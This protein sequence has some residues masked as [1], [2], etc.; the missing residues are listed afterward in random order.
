M[1][2]GVIRRSE[3]RTEGS[4]SLHTPCEARTFTGSSAREGQPVVREKLTR[5]GSSQTPKPESRTDWNRLDRMTD[6]E[7][8]RA[9][10]ADPDAQPLSEDQLARAFRPG[11]LRSLR[12]R[13]GLSQ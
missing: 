1:A 13:L 9:A 12:K 4:S 3:P 7:I 6:E 11:A 8:E 2:K 5:H 10:L